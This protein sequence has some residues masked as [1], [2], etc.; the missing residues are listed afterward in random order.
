MLKSKKVIL[1]MMV[2]FTLAAIFVAPVEAD[3]L[4]VGYVNMQEIAQAHPAIVEAQQDLQQQA[5]QLQQEM[6]TEM[7]DLDPEE[8]AEEMQEMQ[9]GYQEQ[10]QQLE[11][12]Q[13]EALEEEVMPDLESAREAIGVDVI[14]V[15]EA[16]VSGGEEVTEDVLDFFA[17]SDDIGEVEQPQEQDVL[18]TM[19]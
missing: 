11:M 8:D 3:G 9:Q 13:E 4:D 14:V 18:D 17:E 7:G 1:S 5:G 19:P 15:E 2:V 6:Q 12:Q 10:M 16:V